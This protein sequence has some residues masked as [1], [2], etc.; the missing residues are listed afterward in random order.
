[1]TL[2]KKKIF[3]KKM[4]KLGGEKKCAHNPFKYINNQHHINKIQPILKLQFF[5]S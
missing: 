5:R 2:I 4:K 3:S 1:M